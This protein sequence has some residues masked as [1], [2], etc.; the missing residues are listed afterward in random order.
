MAV[1]AK[2]GPT[3]RPLPAEILDAAEQASNK[4]LDGRLLTCPACEIARDVLE[5]KP[6]EY[7]EKFAQQLVAVLIC[8]GC[9]H[10]FALKP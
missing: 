8:P 1:A 7:A 5:Y 4:L 9:N 6:L 3:R 2:I 10:K